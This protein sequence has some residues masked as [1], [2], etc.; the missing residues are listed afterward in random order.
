MMVSTSIPTAAPTPTATPLPVL[1]TLTPEP[2]PA[3]EQKSPQSVSGGEVGRVTGKLCYPSSLPPP[4]TL[5]FQNTVTGERLEHDLAQGEMTFEVELVPGEY[6]AYAHTVGTELAG[7]YS[8]ATVCGRGPDCTNHDLISFQVQ[9]G[10]ATENIDLCDWYTPPGIT[11]WPDAD[12]TS[13]EVQV[14]TLQNMHIYTSPTL[15]YPP[16]QLMPP[17]VSAKALARTADNL[18]VQLAYPPDQ[19]S[20]IYAP[21]TQILGQP[22]RLPVITSTMAGEPVENGSS[23]EKFGQF[24]PTTWSA[25][26]HS[27]LVHFKGT[28]K[29]SS[30]QPVNGFSVLL[31]NGT[32]SVLSHPTGA[33]RHYPDVLEGNWDLVIYNATDAA[34]WWSLTVVSYDCPNFEEGFNAQC[35]SF[36][37]R[38]EPQLVKIVYP[39]RAV[40]KADWVC[41]HD[42]DQGLYQEPYRP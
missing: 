20:W 31:E 41:Q 30:G 32:W 26:P 14:T 28:I 37:R 40:V 9:P 27:H 34:G 25:S 1:P 39:D 3:S 16:L 38:S 42:C 12:S 29:D 10:Q 5:Y 6:T 22:D 18:W 13:S 17:R 21:L 36:T 24:T 8:Q 7:L 15:I 4:M 35:K 33:S 19:Q 11:P 2:T 23:Q